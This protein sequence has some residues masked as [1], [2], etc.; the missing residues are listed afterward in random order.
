M[1]FCAETLISQ[2]FIITLHFRNLADA[3]IQS[4]LNNFYT[5]FI[6]QIKYH[7][8]KYIGLRGALT[9]N[10]TCNFRL[11]DQLFTIYT[12]LPPVRTFRHTASVQ[13]QTAACPPFPEH[14]VHLHLHRVPSKPSPHNRHST[15]PL[16]LASLRP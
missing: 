14:Y 15:F 12:T 7:A 5:A 6:L 8:D 4:D 11:Q 3:R 2:L 9:G 13:G 10:R 1:N 16:P